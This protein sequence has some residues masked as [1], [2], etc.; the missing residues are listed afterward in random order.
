MR[1]A[2]IRLNNEEQAVIIRN[3]EVVLL[4]HLNERLNKQ[5]PL[6]LLSLIEMNLLQSL[7][8]DC[9]RLQEEHW[10]AIQTF[11][12]DEVQFVAPYRNPTHVLGWA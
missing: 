6:S 10:A 5:Y 12:L 8:Q 9:E 3:D 2:T 1:L 4:H 7:Q 11:S